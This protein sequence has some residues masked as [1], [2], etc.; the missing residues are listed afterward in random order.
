MLDLQVSFSHTLKEIPVTRIKTNPLKARNIFE[1]TD[2]VEL[3]RSLKNVGVI[4]PITVR[5]KGG[6]YELICGERRLR[7]ARL[8]GIYSLPCIIMDIDTENSLLIGLTENLQ[9]KNLNFF[10]EAYAIDYYIKITGKTQDEIARKLGKSQSSIANKRRLLKISPDVQ[11]LILE[12]NLRERH[13]R[14]VLTLP[15]SDHMYKAIQKAITCQMGVEKFEE[16]IEKLL[17]EENKKSKPFFKGFCKD[18]R[19][20]VN[21]ISHTVKMMRDSGIETM[22]EKKEDNEKIIYQITIV[23]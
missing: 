21:S 7:A 14:A 6:D 10:E 18:I 5:S 22:L 4:N 12:N 16:Y 3:S 15:D 20:Y 1:E 19:L 9:R 17:S 8:A 23:K 11:R 13:A 2:I